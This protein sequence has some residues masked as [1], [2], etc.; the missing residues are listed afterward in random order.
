MLR[1]IRDASSGKF[2]KAIMSVLFGILIVS[3]GL[4]GIGDIFKGYGQSSLASIG[5]TEISTEQFRTLYT[6][7]LQQIG[8]QIGRPMTP[9][10]ARR[11]GL[12]RQ[13]LQQIIAEAA[14]D[15]EARRLGLAQSD[16][17][18][19]REISSDPNFAGADGKFDP[20]RFAYALRQFGY[21]EQR[22]VSEQRR[23]TLRRQ[24]AGSFTAG[25]APSKTQLD[26][27]TR[28][29][30]EE[31]TIEYI[32]L[33]PDQAGKID[34]PTAEQLQSYFDE[35]KGLFRAPEYRKI[36]VLTVT[37][38]EIGKKITVSDE[39]ARKIFE[40]DKDKYAKPERREIK[41]IAFPTLEA[42][43]AARD[44]IA[45]GL[46][47]EDLAKEM[48]LTDGDTDLGLVTQASVGD[49][50]IAAAAFAAPLNEV[51]QPIKGALAT[52]LIKVT[53]IEPGTTASYDAI[54]PEIKKQIATDRAR[55]EFQ[56]IRNKVEDERGGGANV[57]EA[58]KKLGLEAIT[59][60]AVDRSG[61]TP[62]GQQVKG[63]PSGVDVLTPAFASGVGVE[64]D[65]INFA[66]GELWFDVLGIT[67]SRD[68]A[69]DEVKDQVTTRWH[70]E[71]VTSR[72]RAKGGEIV[73]KLNKGEAFAAAAAAL[74]MDVKKTAPF[75][76]TATVNGLSERVVE[77]AFRTQKDSAGQSE[78]ASGNQW[79]VFKVTD[80]T[81][82]PVDPDSE[83][84]KK[85][86]TAIANAM[87][88][89]QVASYIAHLEDEIGVTINQAA[90]ATATGASTNQ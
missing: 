78:G 42:A 55:G 16:A 13:V 44:K 1:G 24:I 31:R 80:I 30:N 71:Q 87:T 72:L 39:D 22:Y 46:S 60:E 43:K 8:R 6:D 58:A 10:Q 79:V 20:Q 28:Y 75:K 67:P 29:Q 52:A 85:L 18:I 25:I 12:D 36:A 51:S 57:A 90:F 35:R 5:K 59:I 2:G 34:P 4:W 33:G 9:D 45:G 54:A 69:L 83:D 66:G 74:K 48:K 73:E 37:P 26:A 86:K 88:D 65:P 84:A 14:L 17:D 63:L 3:F 53:K 62:D 41:Q 64:T 82:P 76:R 89:E 38:E 11:F 68:R 49:P 23:T 56:D 40:R 77:T 19:V 50:A 15:E 7:K 21:T 47:F 70:D 81:V 61:R 32:Q 27:L